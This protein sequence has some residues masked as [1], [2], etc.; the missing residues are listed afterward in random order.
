VGRA[1]RIVGSLAAIAVVLLALAQLF[2][3]GIAASRVSSRLSRYGVV[4][5][6]SVSAWPAVKLLWGSADSVTVTASSL[7]VDPAQTAALLHEASGVDRLSASV[8]AMREGA[9]AL[10]DVRVV[11]HGDRLGGRG[12]ASESSVDAALPAGMHLQLLSSTGGQVKAR[13]SGQVSVGGLFGAGVSV[14][15]LAGPRAGALIVRPLGSTFGGLHMTL[16]SSP[17]V[18]VEAVGVRALAGPAGEHSYELSIGA[19][20]R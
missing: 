14:D 18:S 15:V 4:K 9:L 17:Y 8:A 1:G 11:K 7:T 3:P 6:V 2:L 5:H 19:R 20:L 12:V 13:A 16:F 10:S